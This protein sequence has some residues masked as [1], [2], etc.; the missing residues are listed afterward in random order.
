MKYSVEW[1]RWD[2]KVFHVWTWDGTNVVMGWEPEYKKVSTAL[3]RLRVLL[4]RSNGRKRS[5]DSGEVN[6]GKA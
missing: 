4:R 5:K 3:A 1:N 6:G 2:S